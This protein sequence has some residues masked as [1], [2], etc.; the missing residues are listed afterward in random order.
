MKIKTKWNNVGTG[1]CSFLYSISWTSNSFQLSSCDTWE[2]NE[3]GFSVG[4]LQ[5]WLKSLVLHGHKCSCQGTIDSIA[6]T[7]SVTAQCLHHQIEGATESEWLWLRP[8]R[9]RVQIWDTAN[10]ARHPAS[11]RNNLW[12]QAMH[13]TFPLRTRTVSANPGLYRSFLRWRRLPLCLTKSIEKQFQVRCVC[14]FVEC[15]I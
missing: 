13:T 2:W 8:Q 3:N 9:E 7:I 4:M 1:M 14:A 15:K 6:H 12:F 5:P 10:T 11:P